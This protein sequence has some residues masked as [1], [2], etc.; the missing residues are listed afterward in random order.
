[1]PCMVCHSK[2]AETVDF[3]AL[4]EIDLCTL[5]QKHPVQKIGLFVN[6]VSAKPV[7]TPF[8]VQSRFL[9]VFLRPFFRFLQILRSF[10]ADLS[11]LHPTA[12]L[13]PLA[14]PALCTSMVF[15]C[16][17]VLLNSVALRMQRAT[18]CAGCETHPWWHRPVCALVLCYFVQKCT[19][20]VDVSIFWDGIFLAGCTTGK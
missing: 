9:L 2:N 11:D 5:R 14:A 10:G 18:V 4:V 16:C 15:A 17:L 8:L 20:T 6:C 13:K 7:Q 12:C 19:N 3:L 1:M